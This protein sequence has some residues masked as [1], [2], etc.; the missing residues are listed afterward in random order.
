MKKLLI[1]VLAVLA[2]SLPSFAQQNT[3]TQT[4]LANDVTSAG[5]ATNATTPTNITV[6][7]ATG[8][9]GSS[10][11]TSI[12]AS[13]PTQTDIYVDRELMT[14]ISV[15]GTQLSVLRGQG[16]TVAAPHRKGA[17]VLAGNPYWFKVND[18]GGSGGFDGVGG[19]SCVLANVVATPWVNVRTGAQ[20]ICSSLSLTWVPGFN[21]PLGSVGS[22][23]FTG[24]VASVAGATLPSGPIFHVTGTNAITSWTIPVGCS[25]NTL[26]TI[27]GCSFVTVPDAA[28]TWA[29]G[30]NIA[31]T[32]T[33]VINL[34]I[35][36][37]WDPTNAKWVA[38]QSK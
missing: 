34:P 29:G 35:I 7:S 20:W 28:F 18:P 24:A 1:A 5:T 11:N 22:A 8:I 17:M 31:L 9:V 33:A 3:L 15:S 38:L 4:T 13:Q 26:A 32:G 10:P 30:G 21:N 16:G 36:W 14:V 23:G 12:T 37:T 19:E 6:T 25:A 2:F 27:G